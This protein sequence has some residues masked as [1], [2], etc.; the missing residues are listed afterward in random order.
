MIQ[1]IKEIIDGIYP[2]SQNSLEE[3]FEL[4]DFETIAKG[5]IFIKLNHPNEKEYFLM[6]GICHSFLSNTD[7]EEVTI[8]F[9]QGKSVL[10]PYTTRIHQGKSVLNFQAL[11]ELQLASV[12]SRKFEEAMI[13]NME[14]RNFANT[15]LR[16]ELHR[17]VS[18]EIGLVSLAARER[19]I[20]FR[21]EFSGL[22]NLIP[23]AAIA[24]YLGI[25]NVSLS[26]LRKEISD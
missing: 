26:R 18:K 7:G 25:T 4:L 23:H 11:T 19:L 24:S 13:Q 3:L 1:K 12:S 17:K 16:N 20:I 8:S 15:V 10:S 9:F 14:I 21:K 6:N 2:V 5:D 22:E